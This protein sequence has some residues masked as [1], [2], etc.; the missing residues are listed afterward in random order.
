M[1]ANSRSGRFH[2]RSLVLFIMVVGVLLGLNVKSR[3]GNLVEPLLGEREEGL[4]YAISYGWPWRA[5]QYVESSWRIDWDVIALG[6]NVCVGGIILGTMF[7]VLR[8]L[9]RSIEANEN[10]PLG[11]SKAKVRFHLRSLVLFILVVG[12]LLGLNVVPQSGDLVVPMLW[13]HAEGL[14]YAKSYGWPWPAIQ[15]IEDTSQIHWGAA[16]FSFDLCAWGSILGTTFI[17]LKAL[18]KN[19]EAKEHRR[20]GNFKAGAVEPPKTSNE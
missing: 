1:T 13:Y 19:T 9:E 12:A 7:V 16:A 3:S 4:K 2:L 8:A 20:I 18:E 6:F 10:N 11:N 17:V 15:Y 5:V 14:K